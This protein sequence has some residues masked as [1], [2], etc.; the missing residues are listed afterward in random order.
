MYEKFFAIDTIREFFRAMAISGITNSMI[1]AYPKLNES[2]EMYQ[3]ISQ[4]IQDFNTAKTLI[5]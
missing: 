5:K 4:S 2:K 3:K 1:E